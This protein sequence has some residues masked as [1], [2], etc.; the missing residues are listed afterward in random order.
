MLT[1]MFGQLTS[2]A[3]LQMW[4][5]LLLAALQLGR[6]LPA[7]W[8]LTQVAEHCLILTAYHCLLLEAKHCLLHEASRCL[9]LAADPSLL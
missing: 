8:Q 5:G 4:M 1:L 2:A 6:V 3:E 9:L 7:L